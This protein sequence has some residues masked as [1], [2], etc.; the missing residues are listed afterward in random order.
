MPNTKVDVAAGAPNEMAFTDNGDGTVT[1]D[2]TR[3]IWQQ[4]TPDDSFDFSA[5][6]TFCGNLKLAGQTG[7]RLPSLIELQ[8]IADLGRSKPAID[9][10]IF[11][12]TPSEGF[13][14]SSVWG[15]NPAAA[16]TVAFDRGNLRQ[17]PKETRLRVRCV[18]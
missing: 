5:A 18:R 1:D 12:G 8:S 2:V 4:A 3:L 11:P 16:A 6:N 14:S 7:W 17:Q 10:T 15:S 13:W 9:T